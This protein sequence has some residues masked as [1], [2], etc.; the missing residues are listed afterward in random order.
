MGYFRSAWRRHSN[1]SR[2]RHGR[3]NRGTQWHDWFSSQLR[4]FAPL[5]LLVGQDSRQRFADWHFGTGLYQNVLDSAGLE[6]F[7][8]DGAFLRFHYGN[9][10]ASLHLLPAFDQP[11]H[12][13]SGFHIRAERGHSEFDHDQILQARPS[14]AFAAPMILAGCGIAASSR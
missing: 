7:D 5:R 8:L 3:Q 6:D 11:F 12:Q 1:W 10:I 9:D 2:G 14:A 4:N 13:R